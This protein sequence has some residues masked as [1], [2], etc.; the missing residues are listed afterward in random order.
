MKQSRKTKAQL[1]RESEGLQRINRVIGTTLALGE[2]LHYIIDEV[3]RLFAAQSAS[4]ILFDHERKEAEITTTYGHQTATEPTLR[5]PWVGSMVGW[6]A[7]QKR[8]LRV[9]RLTEKE[10]PTSWA[11]G[12]QLGGN[13]GQIS[14]LLA[15]LWQETEVMGCLEVVWE[16]HH[17]INEEEEQLLE[18]IATQ[19][20]IAIV[21]AR[22]Y[23]EKEQALQTAITSAHLVRSALDVLP[24]SLAM[25]DET[26]KVISVNQVWRKGAE[27]NGL[28]SRSSVEGL[29]YLS[30]CDAAV[31]EEAEEG[32]RFAAGI[33]A[34]L[35]GERETFAME[36]A[37]PT[38]TRKLR[39]LGRVTRFPQAESMRLLVTHEDLTEQKQAEEA[40]RK[41]EERFRALVQNSSDVIT[42]L[43]ANGDVRYNS[44]SIE[45]VLGYGQEE[46][47]GQSVF[48]LLHP[49][50]VNTVLSV[51]TDALSQPGRVVAPEF[52]IRHKNGTWVYLEA[53]GN[54]LLADPAIRGV[55]VNSRDVTA[56]K[57]AEAALQHQFAFEQLVAEISKNFINLAPTEIDQGIVQALQTVGEFSG[58]DRSY[59]CLFSPDRTTV[60]CTHEWCAS[61]TES[62]WEALQQLPLTP[63]T[64][65]IEKMKEQGVLY[66]PRVAD[67]PTAGMR[68][69]KI[70]QAIGV[71]SLVCIPLMFG[72][73]L[74][75]FLV[76]A[77]VRTEKLWSEESITLLKVIGEIVANA[78]ERKRA[79]EQ[80]QQLHAQLLQTQKLEALGT[81]AG[82]VAHDFNNILSAIMGYAALV[83]DDVPEG[84]LTQRNIDEILTASRRAKT[85]IQQLLTFSRPGQRSRRPV[86]L[87]SVVEETLALLRVSFPKTATFHFACSAEKD[88]VLADPTQIQQM[89]MNLCVN[90]VQAVGGDEGTVTLQL[91]DGNNRDTGGVGTRGV[92]DESSC[93][94]LTISDNGCGI[95]PEIL[96]HIFEPFFTTKPVGQGNGMGLAIVHRIVTS[97]GG[98]I[99][100]DSTP[101]QGTTFRIYWPYATGEEETSDSLMAAMAS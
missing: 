66:I 99:T 84:T 45:Q 78:L 69:Q 20:T 50:D 13:P 2:V 34:V 33:R 35:N 85:L 65:S 53:I 81:L 88:T 83:K 1:Q 47:V 11:L 97:H 58:V 59:L 61:G 31:G 96:D 39:F 22:L 73:V 24:V 8:S 56:R 51:F 18:A 46:L 54:N 67:L 23:Q 15:P 92:H 101:N 14:V 75:G 27:E 72:K 29:N 21:Q 87:R 55:V 93:L 3:V 80:Q 43:D 64:W 28:S 100:V 79:D 70:L 52:R 37:C 68:E 4:V 60:N 77:T 36:Y 38:P 62:Q 76:F 26:G 12:K 95:E 16:P 98:M 9:P 19:A 82:G 42:I 86:H 32:R 90:A 91:D 30:V 57:Q 25:L 63:L 74:G 10:W 7:E 94:C 41:S 44:P 71:Q 40:L 49:E 6:I 48:A 17:S 89:V 5:Y